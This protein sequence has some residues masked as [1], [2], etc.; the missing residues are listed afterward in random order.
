MIMSLC[1]PKSIACAVLAA[2]FVLSV[3][4]GGDVVMAQTSVTKGGEQDAQATPSPQPSKAQ[5]TWMVNCSNSQAGLDCRA[6]QSLF[7]KNTGQRILSVAVRMPADTKKP[8]MLVQVPLGTSL[9]PGTSLQIGQDEAKTLP[10]QSCN[11]A[12]CVAEYAITN[13][14]IAAMLKGADLTISFQTTQKQPIIL[15]VP[16]A[17]FAVAY[18]KIK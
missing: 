1:K 12:G 4:T 17:G 6:G 11:R 5:P 8:V 10:F 15:K 7:L 3:L 13:A 2:G 18:A 14:E 16:S 9:P